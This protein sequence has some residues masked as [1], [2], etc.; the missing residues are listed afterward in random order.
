MKL[1]LIETEPG[2][3]FDIGD[4]LR[5][6]GH[7]VV[8]CNDQYGGPCKGV[9]DHSACPMHSHL[10]LA[11]VARPDRSEATLNEMGGV[12][13]KQH[14]VPLVQIDP[15]DPVVTTDLEATVALARRKVE[16][17]YAAVVRRELRLAGVEHDVNVEVRRTPQR[18]G[19]VVHLPTRYA[20]AAQQAAL[21]DRARH[22]IRTHDPF[23]RV[24]DVS[25]V[26]DG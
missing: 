9:A 16:T 1:L 25:V 11:I 4:R 12:C 7:D 5:E 19:A 2:A 22:A 6:E 24:I 23:V 26:I 10:D 20:L 18:I 21:S 14:R 3:A 13:A 8:Q 15:L 17:E